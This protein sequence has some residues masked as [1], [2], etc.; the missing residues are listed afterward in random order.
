MG[1]CTKCENYNQEKHNCPTFCEV[2]RETCKENKEYYIELLQ[3]M[4]AEI[5]ETKVI[6]PSDGVRTYKA[7]MDVV[8]KYIEKA[9]GK[10][11]V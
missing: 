3:D 4:K 10:S 1:E 9:K 7:I 11:N 6:Y 8:D 2:I 5:N